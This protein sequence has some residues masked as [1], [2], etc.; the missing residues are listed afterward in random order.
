LK[1]SD[2]HICGLALEA[3]AFK[4]MRL[5]DLNYVATR[6]RGAATVALK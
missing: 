4:L 2:K 6:L 5:L 3:L 1:S